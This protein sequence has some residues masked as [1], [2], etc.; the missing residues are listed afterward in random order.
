MRFRLAALI[1]FTASILANSSIA[2]VARVARDQ[3]QGKFY[4]N[5]LRN[6][7]DSQSNWRQQDKPSARTNQA[8]SQKVVQARSQLQA[9]ANEAG[10]LITALRYEEQYSLHARGLLGEAYGVKAVADVLLS[11]TSNNNL[12]DEQLTSEFAE[13]DRQWHLLSHQLQQTADLGNTVIS[14]N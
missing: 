7:V 11:R 3:S 14:F 2:Q 12:T 5:V 10:Q 4:D 6:L 1:V 9:F 8:Q 13:L